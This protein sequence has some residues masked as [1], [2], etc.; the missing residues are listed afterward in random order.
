VRQRGSV[1]V[2]GHDSADGE[3]VGKRLRISKQFRKGYS[4]NF[5]CR[6]FSEVRPYHI[7]EDLRLK[8]QRSLI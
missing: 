6:G 3:E 1:R 7:L 5:A 4:A 2:R 8:F